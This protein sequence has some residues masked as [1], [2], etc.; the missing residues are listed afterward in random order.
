[1]SGS[2]QSKDISAMSMEELKDLADEIRAR[3]IDVTSKTG[4]HLAP[5]LGIVEITLALHYV[6]NFPEDKVVWDVG[7]QA[8]VHKLLTGRNDNFDT[9][10]QWQGVSG[11]PKRSE[12]EYD[13][14][15]AGHAS[16]S[17]SAAVGFAAARDLQHKKNEVI[18]VIGDGAM[19]GGMAFE[20]LNH[21]SHLNTKMTIILN[22]NEMSIDPNIGG[23]S[24]YLTRIR[25]DPSYNRMKDDV[26]YILKR[27]PNIGPKMADFA[28]RLKESVKH[29]LVQG[30]F[31]E[32]LGIK[33]L[34]P[35]NGHDIEELIRVF[36]SSKQFDRPVLIHCLTEK[37]KGYLPAEAH[38]EKFHGVGPFEIET[39]ETK[40]NATTPSYTDVF[41]DTLVTLAQRDKRIV[42]ITA[43]MASGTGMNKLAKAFPDRMFDVGIAEEHATTMASAMAL[44]GL[45]PVLALYS[46]F[47]QRGYDQLIHDCALQNAPVVFALDRAGLVGAD[48]PTHHGVFD[49]SFLRTVPGLTVMAPKDEPELQ[50]MLYSA[51][52]YNRPVALRYPRGSGIG[53]DLVTEYELLPYGKAEVLSE[54][55]DATIFAIGSM[56]MPAIETAALLEEAGFSAGVVN[57][58]FEK[59]IDKECLLEKADSTK[60]IITMEENALAAGFGSAVVE[61]LED[62]GRCNKV[63]RFGIPDDFVPHGDT[64]IL[65]NELGLTPEKMAA[66]IADDLK[67]K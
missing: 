19:T 7:H 24:Q 41:A 33:Y 4:G 45:K 49:L 31:F 36:E 56:V 9:L 20:G 32:E 1:M 27:I 53:H 11:F 50:H 51:L 37:G 25:L 6:Y 23:M 15:G 65:K 59:P 3:L 38:P 35:V 60:C 13:A 40:K 57:A 62:N 43:A 48:G 63:V 16:T 67:R 42:G 44:S 29:M 39:G 66:K 54:G 52:E 2:I 22:D 17:I 21:A 58:R 64:A 12:S 5:N 55:S 28:D 61:T 14:F 30:S 46:S 18:A 8:Y 34:G 26:E 10:R 47:M